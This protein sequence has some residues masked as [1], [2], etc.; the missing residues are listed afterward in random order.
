[1]TNLWQRVYREIRTTSPDTLISSYRGDVCA[2]TGSLYMNNGPPPNS[3]NSIATCSKPDELGQYFHPTEMHGITIQEGPDGNS[4]EM[5][6][7][8]FWHPWVCAKNITGCPW[9]GHGNASRIFDSYLKTVGHGAVLNMN[10]PPER[11]GRMNASVA[12][13]MREVGQALNDT[14]GTS[15]ASI[16]SQLATKCATASDATVVDVSSKPFDYIVIKEDLSQGQRIANYS[17]EF[18]REGSSTWEVMVTAGGCVKHNCTNTRE[19]ASHGFSDRP[20]GHDPRDQ[21][22]GHKRIDMPIVPTS[23]AGRVRVAKVRFSCHQTFA[24][25]IHV[26]S[27]ALH[28]KNVPWETNIASLE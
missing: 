3:T 13:V 14:F 22:V 23:G 11:T 10:I 5:P 6:T 2:S 19:S 7:Y 24:D 1:M 12:A 20:D 15:V 8:W 18:Q 16:P 28:L 17:V 25:P 26:R 27:F 4:D 9:V 21:Y